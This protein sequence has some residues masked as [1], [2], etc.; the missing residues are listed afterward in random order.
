MREI[1]IDLDQPEP[2][3]PEPARRAPRRLVS[4]IVLTL[5]VATVVLVV[6][7]PSLEPPTATLV[8]P[9]PTWPVPAADLGEAL[10]AAVGE[11]VVLVTARRG[12]SGHDRATGALLWRHPFT[13]RTGAHLPD[14][15]TA[16]IAGSTFVLRP[17]ADAPGDPP[18]WELRGLADGELLAGGEKNPRVGEG[19]FYGFVTGAALVEVDCGTSACEVTGFDLADGRELWRRAEAPTATVIT[20]SGLLEWQHRTSVGFDWSGTRPDPT[21]G[22]FLL[23]D[24]S[25]DAGPSEGTLR[26]V[27]LRDGRTV[28]SWRTD[29]EH[30][31][32]HH[33][34][35]DEVL[36]SDGAAVTALNPATGAE[37]WVSEGYSL[38]T[39]AFGDGVLAHDGLVLACDRDA[40]ALL[41]LAD[42]TT[43]DP[44]AGDDVLY[45]PS[46]VAVARHGNELRAH[47]LASGTE[48]WRMALR[49]TGWDDFTH[50]GTFAGGGVLI[51][52][53]R[54]GVLADAPPWTLVVDLETGASRSWSGGRVLGHRDGEAI[55]YDGT[56]RSVT[57]G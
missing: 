21:A 30:L 40:T 3:T 49:S 57:V 31:W 35:G 37:R 46:G 27:G 5:A 7:T 2:P 52:D 17:S 10:H 9:P 56:L 11:E 18:R 32:G 28:G 8:E 14:A 25:T 29:A 42:G 12:L 50:H 1:H 6:A 34:V 4:A 54:V 38:C 45:L 41:D 53:G 16:V 23:A 26:T 33:V 24:F 39:N 43:S 47:D 15:N 20:P 19:F 48:R 36:H 51:L 55:V 22:V 13:E 44:L